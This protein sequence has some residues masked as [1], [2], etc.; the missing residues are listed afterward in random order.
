MLIKP[1]QEISEYIYSDDIKNTIM[2]LK[3]GTSFNQMSSKTL[4]DAAR[5]LADGM[6]Y[7]IN[8][9]GLPHLSKSQKAPLAESVVVRSLV[10]LYCLWNYHCK[11]LPN[12]S[13]EDD[14]GYVWELAV[15]SQM[16]L[17]HNNNQY[18]GLMKLAYINLSLARAGY[19]SD[20]ACAGSPHVQACSHLLAHAGLIIERNHG[21]KNKEEETSQTIPSRRA[22]AMTPQGLILSYWIFGDSEWVVR[23]NKYVYMGI[24][25]VII[26]RNGSSRIGWVDY[27][28]LSS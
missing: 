8:S 24:Q 7:I 21:D 5:N 4:G 28:A 20:L 3:S 10:M 22:F 6:R 9:H 17:C 19:P 11:H 1:P 27:L 13:I 23:R 15:P 16:E 26:D 2:L 18:D 14:E 25:P 12:T